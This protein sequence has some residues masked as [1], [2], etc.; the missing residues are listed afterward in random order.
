METSKDLKL[1]SAAFEWG[2]RANDSA[3]GGYARTSSQFNSESSPVNHRFVTF[4]GELTQDRLLNHGWNVLN[5][6]HETQLSA[7]VLFPESN[8]SLSDCYSC[9]SPNLPNLTNPNA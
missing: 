9:Q 3:L 7:W 8:I 6:T 5:P 4:R 1:F 2:R